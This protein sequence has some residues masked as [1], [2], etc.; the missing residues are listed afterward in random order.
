MPMTEGSAPEFF[1]LSRWK[2]MVLQAQDTK[3]E[4]L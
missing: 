1:S 3:A 4:P 2:G